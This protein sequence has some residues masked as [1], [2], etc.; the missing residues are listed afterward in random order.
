[1]LAT[2]SA[3]WARAALTRWAVY[4]YTPAGLHVMAPDDLLPTRHPDHRSDANQASGDR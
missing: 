2:V 1:M 3:S 4:L